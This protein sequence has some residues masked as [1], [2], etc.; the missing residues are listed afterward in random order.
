LCGKFSKADLWAGLA[1]SHGLILL[2]FLLRDI[3]CGS[4]S[5]RQLLNLRDISND[6]VRLFF[7]A[8]WFLQ[9]ELA[10]EETGCVHA[11]F[12]AGAYFAGWAVADN[13]DLA[14]IQPRAL[15]D[16]AKCCFFGQNVITI[17]EIDFFD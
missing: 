11:Q 13:K 9:L 1:D 3:C 12:L 10:V 5:E 17:S 7:R 6:V 8:D 2:N 4:P 14:G 16:L 15:L